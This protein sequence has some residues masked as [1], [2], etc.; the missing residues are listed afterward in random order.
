[1]PIKKPK[2]LNRF[3]LLD[4]WQSKARCYRTQEAAYVHW[5]NLKPHLTKEWESWLSVAW[6]H[7]HEDSR[8]PEELNGCLEELRAIWKSQESV[9]GY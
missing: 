1:M 8:S 2:P 4:L 9:T 7:C 3:Q 5:E 6:G